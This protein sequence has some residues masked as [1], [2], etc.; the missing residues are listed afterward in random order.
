MA[1]PVLRYGGSTIW[2]TDLR[3]DYAHL[4]DRS[5]YEGIN[6]PAPAVYGAPRGTCL[7]YLNSGQPVDSRMNYRS[8]SFGNS[9]KYDMAE[10]AL[11]NSLDL[12]AFTLTSVSS[13]FD[14]DFTGIDDLAP[15]P[16]PGIGGTASRTP[17]YNQENAERIS[18]ELRL[19]SSDDRPFQYMLGA[20]YAHEKVESDYYVGTYFA[21]FG[22][23]AGAGYTAA[24]PIATYVKFNQKTDTWSAF[25]SLTAELISN[26]SLD[27]GLRYTEVSKTVD[28]DS[29]VG[30][31][32]SIPQPGAF[33][34]LL[35]P[36][37]SV[38]REVLGI[39]G[40]NYAVPRLDNSKL[41]PSAKL[42]YRF[43]SDIM[44]YASY[45]KG[46]KA[47][48]F[49]ASEGKYSFGPETV[50]AFEV[51]LKATLFDRR[52]FTSI[53]LFRSDYKDLQ[54]ATN[55][56]NSSGTIISVITN[57]ARSR[58]QGVEFAVNAK[59]SDALSI[60]AE[61][62]YLDAKY[63]AYPNGAC[64][65]LDNIT[66]GCIQNMSG[67][68]RGFSPELS[69]NF[70]LTYTIPL[71][72]LELKFEPLVYFTSRY[73]QSATAD[74]LLSQPGYSKVDFRAS[75]ATIDEKWELAVIGKNLTDKKT[76]AF[77]NQF[78]GAPG[79]FW[80]YPERPRSVAVQASLRF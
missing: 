7:L 76:S 17:R 56:V 41:L 16:V 73:F 43:S 24:T 60:R 62:A 19:A 63:R 52:L 38:M 6:C 69:G 54:E 33:T 37:L 77:R 78:A 79:T 50:D 40:G 66:P 21:P 67:K 30:V 13:Y 65:I 9:S 70:G 1:S 61:I 4:R 45:S 12:G 28:R 5:L 75:L 11:T 8:G 55:T 68:R 31:G 58:S 36:A 18:Q 20:Y 53:A 2:R 42:S 14:H 25:G 23:F 47:G 3:V 51:G 48:G 46:F 49:A 34:P 80:V 39:P 59:V 22:A 15:L 57:A 32:G 29:S 26:L 44:G 35:D 71:D 10:V 64:T 72:K 74:A 27:L